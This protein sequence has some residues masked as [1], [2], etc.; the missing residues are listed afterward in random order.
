MF[1]LAGLG[2]NVKRIGNAG[3]QKCPNCNNWKPQGV[4]EISK[5]ATAFFVPIA[6]WSKEY[7]VICPICQAGLPVKEGKLNE[8]LQKSI[9]IPDDQKATEIWSDIDS[10]TVA[11]L[12]EILKTTGGTSGD[13]HAA[14]AILM[15]TIQKEI[16]CKYTK[17]HFEPILASYI[18]SMADVMEI[19]LS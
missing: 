8:L 9:T 2:S 18:R 13:N 4:Y 15:Q 19:K 16:A 17:E 14:L 10:V 3:F 12:V 11:N 7:Y 1:F 6:K 5:Q